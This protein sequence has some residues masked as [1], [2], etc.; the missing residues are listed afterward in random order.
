MNLLK[1][2]NLKNNYGFQ[3]NIAVQNSLVQQI[4]INSD[5]LLLKRSLDNLTQYF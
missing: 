4:K 1:L 2:Q 3:H 5:E